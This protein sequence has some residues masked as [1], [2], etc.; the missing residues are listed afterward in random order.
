MATRKTSVRQHPKR[1]DTGRFDWRKHE[2]EIERLQT[3]KK[4][5]KTTASRAEIEQ[6][7]RR[8][9]YKK[10]VLGADKGQKVQYA[11]TNPDDT[12]DHCRIFVG[13][14]DVIIE[15][16]TDLV[17]PTVDPIGHVVADVGYVAYERKHGH[18]ENRSKIVTF[19]KRVK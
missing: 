19:K 4:K 13:Q 17:S 5:G 14:D 2:R 9:G 15:E 16:H 11:K 12:Q 7:Y 1:R 18:N 8:A 3:D 6:R 10:T